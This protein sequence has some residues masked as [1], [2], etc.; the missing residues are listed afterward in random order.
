MWQCEVE[1]CS[2]YGKKWVARRHVEI[3]TS[4]RNKTSQRVRKTGQYKLGTVDL[5]I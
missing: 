4:S 2:Q 3:Y 5:Q 1:T